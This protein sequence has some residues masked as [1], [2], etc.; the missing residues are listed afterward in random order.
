M[1]HLL[2]RVLPNRLRWRWLGLPAGL[3]LIVLMV[4]F[5]RGERGDAVL[6]LVALGDGGRYAPS[7]RIPPSRMD[8]SA[9]APE[10]A[11]RIPLVLAVRNLGGESA[12]P[13]R[14]RLSVPV[15]FRIQVDGRRLLDRA[16]SD[17]P[18][19]GYRLDTRTLS[20]PPEGEGGAV[21]LRDTVWL[22]VLMPAFYCAIIGD[23]VPAF[24]SAPPIPVEPL[25]HVRMFY[26]L[27]G[28]DLDYPQTGLLELRLDPTRL[29]LPANNEF[30]D[31]SPMRIY[32]DEAPFPSFSALRRSGSRRSLCGGIGDALQFRTFLWTTPGGGRFFV[33]HYGGVPRKYLFDMNRNNIIELEIAD[34]DGNGTFEASRSLRL[35]IPRFLVPQPDG[36]RFRLVDREPLT[37]EEFAR[38]RAFGSALAGPY[39][40]ISQPPDT[41]PDLYVFGPGMT[42]RDSDDEG[43]GRTI[44]P[45]ETFR[46]GNAGAPAPGR[47]SPGVPIAPPAAQRAAAAGAQAG[48]TPTDSVA[49]PTPAQAEPPPA[50]ADDR[51][52]LLGVPV[53]SAGAGSSPPDSGGG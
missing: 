3:G 10:V 53:D 32:R 38:L 12:H 47:P 27:E 49:E 18:L 5:L 13:E 14:L 33:I 17:G 28:G 23:S 42:I 21:A 46:P 36:R 19:I 8:T 39:E 9:A 29:R 6:E 2:M 26:V 7:V 51:R 16:S 43:P 22:E 44:G 45:G 15:F 52:D 20:I 30:V 31:S 35:P 40:P 37:P 34:M 50:P 1:R 25:A 41:T 48:G 11:A 4:L 24:I